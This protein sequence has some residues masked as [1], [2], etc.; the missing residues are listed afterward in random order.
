MKV[1]LVKMNYDDGQTYD[2]MAHDYVFTAFDSEEKA[3]DFCKKNSDEY[4]ETCKEYK[5]LTE[6]TIIDP[7]SNFSEHVIPYVN[8][9]YDEI[10]DFYWLTIEELIV[11]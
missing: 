8:Q 6:R 4:D 10:G 3:I 7:G 5:I 2:S 9:C 1:Y 11:S